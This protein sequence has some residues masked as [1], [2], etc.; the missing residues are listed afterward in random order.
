MKVT[1]IC[2]WCGEPGCTWRRHGA[3]VRESRRWVEHEA[4]R[5]MELSQGDPNPLGEYW[6]EY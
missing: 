2:E 1:D 4:P 6:P 3:A 5:L